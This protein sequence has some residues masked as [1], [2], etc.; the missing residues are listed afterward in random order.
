[1][2]PLISPASGAPVSLSF[3]FTSE[4]PVFHSTGSPPWERIQ[5]KSWR[6]HF[7]SKMTF[8]PGFRCSTSAAKSISWRS[9]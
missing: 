2:C 9:G 5:P 4:W 1:M 8:A 7:T 3:A 6:V